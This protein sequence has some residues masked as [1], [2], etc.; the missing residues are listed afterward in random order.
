M[1]LQVNF[2]RVRYSHETCYN[3]RPG[4]HAVQYEMILMANRDLA[5][6]DS[7]KELL[8]QY[9]ADVYMVEAFAADYI[10]QLSAAV[11]AGDADSDASCDSLSGSVAGGPDS[12][13]GMYSFFGFSFDMVHFCKTFLEFLDSVGF[14]CLDVALLGVDDRCDLLLSFYSTVTPE[15]GPFNISERQYS[16]AMLTEILP[17]LLVDARA[18]RVSYHMLCRLKL[19]ILHLVR[20]LALEWFTASL[21]QGMFLFVFMYNKMFLALGKSY[22]DFGRSELQWGMFREYSVQAPHLGGSIPQMQSVGDRGDFSLVLI[23]RFELVALNKKISVFGGGIYRTAAVS[24]PHIV[25]V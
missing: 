5:S 10:H 25:S 3:D 16:L 15:H 24:D 9:S 20:M 19:P 13:A 21:M 23:D 22:P 4:F 14:R 11:A 7:V 12:S 6:D 1:A 2:P 17:A 18:G 8:L